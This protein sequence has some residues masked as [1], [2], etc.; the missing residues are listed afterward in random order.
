MVFSLVVG[1]LL[2]PG[3]LR[4]VKEKGTITLLD[5]YLCKGHIVA[6][7]MAFQGRLK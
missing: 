4:P 3:P 6:I 7:S 1:P 5:T 2:A